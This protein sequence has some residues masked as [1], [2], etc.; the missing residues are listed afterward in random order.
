RGC[1]ATAHRATRIVEIW[2][3]VARSVLLLL[4]RPRGQLLQLSIPVSLL[5][6]QAVPGPRSGT[7][8]I[9]SKVPVTPCRQASTSPANPSLTAAVGMFFQQT[10]SFLT[11]VHRLV[12]VPGHDLRL[13]IWRR[14]GQGGHSDHARN[15]HVR[16]GEKMRQRD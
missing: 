16:F 14:F 1:L 12:S 9:V 3:R 8:A 5:I 4:G 6:T 15:R 7:A 13:V 11:L 10:H 2:P